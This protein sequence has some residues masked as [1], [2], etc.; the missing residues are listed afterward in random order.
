MVKY[1]EENIRESQ[2]RIYDQNA[3][4]VRTMETRLGFPNFELNRSVYSGWIN[5]QTFPQI[6]GEK[7]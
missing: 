6:R 4:V 5:N 7:K 2:E 1:Q 3:K